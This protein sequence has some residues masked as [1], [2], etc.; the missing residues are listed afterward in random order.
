MP[1]S[2]GEGNRLRDWINLILAALLFISPWVLGFASATVPA[3]NAW[4]VGVVLAVLAIAAISASAE[5]EE[6][7]SALLGVWLIISPW[8]LRFSATTDAVRA[9]VILGVLTVSPKTRRRTSTYR[10]ARCGPACRVV[11]QGTWSYKLRA[12]C[13]SL[14][15]P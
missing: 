1:I 3:W 9:D 6:W 15:S 5:W 10:T 8:V 4:I 12:L 2:Y 13:R 11:G 14:I 7:I